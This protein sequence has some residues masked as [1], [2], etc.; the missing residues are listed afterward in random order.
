MV[1][2]M[3]DLSHICLGIGNQSIKVQVHLAEWALA[4]TEV[5]PDERSR[6]KRRRWVLTKLTSPTWAVANISKFW[7]W[8]ERKLCVHYTWS[9]ISIL[10]DY[11]WPPTQWQAYPLVS[12]LQKPPFLHSWFTQSSVFISHLVSIPFF[13][14]RE[15]LGLL[16]FTFHPPILEHMC[17][18]PLVGLLQ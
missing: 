7:R 16:M 5:I 14:L 4:N 6:I 11:K 18:T 17:R 9:D 1:V 3:A 15:T 12:S 8:A 2:H 13:S 10:I